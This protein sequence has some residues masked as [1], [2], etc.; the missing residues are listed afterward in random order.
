MPWYFESTGTQAVVSAA[1][2]A[3]A[4]TDVTAAEQTALTNAKTQ[5]AAQLTAV[6]T[7]SGYTQFRMVMA[8][9]RPNLGSYNRLLVEGVNLAPSGEIMS[10]SNPSTYP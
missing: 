1:L 10:K 3:Y 9:A 4:I 6:A 8:G 7:S 2:T 5:A